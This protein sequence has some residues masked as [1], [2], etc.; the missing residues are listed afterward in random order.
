M[1]NIHTWC[2]AAC[3]YSIS[4]TV[5][6][7]GT[8]KLVH[9]CGKSCPHLTFDFGEVATWFNT[10]V[11]KFPSPLPPDRTT[12]LLYCTVLPFQS[13]LSEIFLFYS[14]TN[15]VCWRNRNSLLCAPIQW[16]LTSLE[17]DVTKTCSLVYKCAVWWSIDAAILYDVLHVY[18]C[19][20]G[21]QKGNWFY[22]VFAR[23]HDIMF[24]AC[25]PIR[26]R[27]MSLQYNKLFGNGLSN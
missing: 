17:I 4:C 5:R 15:R 7:Q 9:G 27:E 25:L 8:W 21:T 10:A 16:K 2:I 6:W 12:N 19:L 22:V 23:E 26:S 1:A 14:F 18:W 13:A 20:W 24:P 3:M 11:N